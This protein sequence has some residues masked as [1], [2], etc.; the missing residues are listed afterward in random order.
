MAENSKKTQAFD[1]TNERFKYLKRM[2]KQKKNTHSCKREATKE[3][4]NTCGKSY[5]ELFEH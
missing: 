4:K 1:V 2:L 3:K 5:I